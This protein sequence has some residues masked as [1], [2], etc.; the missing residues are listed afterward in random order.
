MSWYEVTPV[1][2]ILDYDD[3]QCLLILWDQ[4]ES[5]P[6]QLYLLFL[7]RTHSCSTKSRSPRSIRELK[8]GVSNVDSVFTFCA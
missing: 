7:I 1:I 4:G 6:Q 2:E 5:D 3:F 8:M